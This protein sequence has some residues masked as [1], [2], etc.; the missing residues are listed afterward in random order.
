[1]VMP[2]PGKGRIPIVKVTVAFPAPLFEQMEGIVRGEGRWLS[3]V[4]F[5]RFACGNEVERHS[6]KP[7]SVPKGTRRVDSKG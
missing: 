5:V 7:R 2:A 4:D 6:G 1:M 3:V